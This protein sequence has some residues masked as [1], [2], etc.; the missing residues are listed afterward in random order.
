M[1][2]VFMLCIL[3]FH[4]GAFIVFMSCFS[5]IRPGLRVVRCLFDRPGWVLLSVPP[6]QLLFFSAWLVRLH[7]RLSVC[8]TCPLEPICTRERALKD[9]RTLTASR[10]R[11]R[12][13]LIFYSDV[14]RSG[15][16]ERCFYVQR[17]RNI[18][19]IEWLFKKKFEYFT[20]TT[21]YLALVTFRQ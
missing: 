11:A 3:F 21:F 10:E 1:C 2:F 9:T 12:R 5:S 4:A 6:H 19:N 14:S 7:A 13:E 20:K 17:K 8:L 15:K 16:V 18:N